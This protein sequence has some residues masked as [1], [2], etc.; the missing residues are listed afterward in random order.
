[1]SK[2][3]PLRDILDDAVNR[4]KFTTEN[5]PTLHLD[6]D[7]SVTNQDI[8]DLDFPE[9]IQEFMLLLSKVEDVIAAGRKIKEQMTIELGDRYSGQAIR[10]A[11]K[12]IVGRPST[13]YKPY[14]K[15]KV[16]DYLG[17][18]W[19]SVVRPEFRVTGVKAVAESRGDDPNVIM[20]SLF[21]KVITNN[22]VTILPESKAPKYLQQLDEGEV[23]ELGK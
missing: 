15:E 11:G 5:L 6:E 9:D 18:D 19:R 7:G 23:K 16:L 17:D 12:V 22:N 3:K 14:D 4:V 21:E 10:N 1:M 2:Q 20:E 8:V 13:S